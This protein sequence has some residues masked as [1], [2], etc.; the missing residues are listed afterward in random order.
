MN[1]RHK[2]RLSIRRRLRL[3]RTGCSPARLTR[4]RRPMCNAMSWSLRKLRWRGTIFTAARSTE[5]MV[6]P[7]NFRCGLIRRVLGFRLQAGS[8]WKRSL[9]L[10]CYPVRTRRS[11]L[12]VGQSCDPIPNGDHPYAA[13]GFGRR[14]RSFGGS[15]SPLSANRTDS[16]CGELDASLGGEAARVSASPP[17]AFGADPPNVSFLRSGPTAIRRKLCRQKFALQFAGGCDRSRQTPRWWHDGICDA[18]A[19]RDSCRVGGAAN[20]F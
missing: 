13:N 6:R 10:S 20:R 2:P 4:M 1:H 18:V 19:I 11:L 14:Y 5:F 16:S 3:R 8:I 15:S 9:R 12:H 17:K 7:W